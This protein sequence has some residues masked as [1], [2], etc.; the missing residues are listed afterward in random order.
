VAALLAVLG[1]GVVGL[2]LYVW[3]F[4]K[5]PRWLKRYHSAAA[6]V[7]VTTARPDVTRDTFRLRKMP[8]DVDYIIIG[9]G[10]GGLYCAGVL[11]RAGFKVVVL[12]QHY[13]TG[14]CTHEFEDHGY[15]LCVPA[16]LGCCARARHPILTHSCGLD[17]FI[18]LQRYRGALR[19]QHEEVRCS[20]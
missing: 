17:G 16:L 13:V 3:R 7:N 8:K 5:K 6:P 1:V 20:H 15:S 10:M 4:R 9:S 11:A 2:V 19:G 18:C 12:E 14:G